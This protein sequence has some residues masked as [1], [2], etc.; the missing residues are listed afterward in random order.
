[1]LTVVGIDRIMTVD[2]HAD[3]IQGFFSIPVDNIYGSPILLD[4]IEKQN[5][6]NMKYNYA[7]NAFRMHDIDSDKST[8]DPNIYKVMKKIKPENKLN[9]YFK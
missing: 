2:L 6:E 7:N 3:Q 1:M 4:D 8:I 5:Y 9:F